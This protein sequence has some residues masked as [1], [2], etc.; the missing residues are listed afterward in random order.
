MK[1]VINKTKKY[2]RF[3]K[4]KTVVLPRAGLFLIMYIKG[5]SEES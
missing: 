3:V 5:K 1:K 4:K 2:P